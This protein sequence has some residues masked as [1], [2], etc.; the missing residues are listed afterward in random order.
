MP[1]YTTQEKLDKLIPLTDTEKEEGRK[2]KERKKWERR[3]AEGR[4]RRRYKEDDYERAYKRFRKEYGVPESAQQ[5][6]SQFYE[7]SK[8]PSFPEDKLKRSWKRDVSEQEERERERER[9]R[10]LRKRLEEEAERKKRRKPK[11]RFIGTRGKY[12]YYYRT[13]HYRTKGGRYRTKRTYTRSRISMR[14][15]RGRKR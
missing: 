15:S 10:Q 14:K 12:S 11:K 7:W 2:Y 1:K 13:V 8:S 9:K 4:Y 6:L 5:L 3:K